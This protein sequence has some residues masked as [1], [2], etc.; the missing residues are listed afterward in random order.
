MKNYGTYVFWSY[1]DIYFFL[2][3]L[4]QLHENIHFYFRDTFTLKSFT[5]SKFE[6]KQP[7]PNY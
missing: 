4:A 6:D 3:S 1:M 5:W 7:L 2:S